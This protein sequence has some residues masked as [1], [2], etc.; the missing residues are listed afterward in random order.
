MKK[1]ISF[2]LWGSD[3]KY[4]VGALENVRLQKEV[5]P[6]WICRFYVDPLVPVQIIWQLQEEAEV[7][8]KDPSDGYLG[9]FWRF[10]PAYEDIERFIVRDCDSRLNKREAAAVQEWID[11]GLPFH[12]MRDHRGH[13]IPVLGAMWGAVGNFLPDFKALYEGFVKSIKAQ[14]VNVKRER[15]F[16]TDQYFLNRIVWPRISSQAIVHDDQ[17]RF[18]GKERPFTEKLPDGQFIGQQWGS[19]NKPLRVPL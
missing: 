7:V 6:D 10:E 11:S 8:Y 16:Y 13:D 5:Y 14:N 12:C 17:K 1:I 18:S 2:S 15:F 19:D 9:L 3:P 4:T